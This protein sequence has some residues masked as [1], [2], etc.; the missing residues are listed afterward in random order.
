MLG[1]ALGRGFS[2]GPLGTV[3]VAVLRGATWVISLLDRE[4]VR[5]MPRRTKGVFVFCYLS[6]KDIAQ[7]SVEL[8]ALYYL[9]AALCPPGANIGVFRKAN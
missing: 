8:G 3:V 9:W 2:A 5:S 6:G 4:A 7:S 1:C